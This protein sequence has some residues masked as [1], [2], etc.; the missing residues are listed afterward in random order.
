LFAG[1]LVVALIGWNHLGISQIWGRLGIGG[2]GDWMEALLVALHQPDFWLWFYLTFAISSTMFPSS[3]DWR[4]WP[5]LLVVFLILLVLMLIAGAGPWL[6]DHLAP[7]LNVVVESIAL[8]IGL[9]LGVHLVLFFPF[10]LGR[11][12]ISRITGLEVV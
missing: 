3:T 11:L 10:Y 8:I 4:A 9:S 6:I 5:P 1:G 2:W 7:A 12:A